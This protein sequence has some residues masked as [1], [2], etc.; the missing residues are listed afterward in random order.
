M[1]FCSVGAA[2]AHNTESHFSY[3]DQFRV[4]LLKLNNLLISSYENK[5]WHH[6]YDQVLL[7]WPGWGSLQNKFPAAQGAGSGHCCPSALIPHPQ[8]LPAGDF[9]ST[10]WSGTE[11]GM[12]QHILD[13]SVRV[14]ALLSTRVGSGW[15]WAGSVSHEGDERAE[16]KAEPS[17]NWAGSLNEVEADPRAAGAD[18]LCCRSQLT[19][20]SASWR[21]MGRRNSPW[22]HCARCVW[23]WLG[24]VT[25]QVTTSP[26]KLSSA[27]T[28]HW[29]STPQSPPAAS[30]SW[31]CLILGFKRCSGARWGC[32][33]R[34]T[35]SR[36]WH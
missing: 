3:L 7:Q 33:Q 24:A 15:G 28:E 10:G 36:S 19:N 14:T 30:Q 34:R 20:P 27:V 4:I 2:V 12:L 1:H 25:P 13:G 8:L 32:R 5:M 22:A 35:M 26:S 29:I 23:V 6:Y 21:R 9:P 18:S 17:L 16:G 31:E 11:L